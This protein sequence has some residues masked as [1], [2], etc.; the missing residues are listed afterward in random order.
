MQWAHE[1]K[2]D[3]F[4]DVIYT[5]ECT[6]Q[7]ESYR[8]FC[9]QKKGE[10]PCPK[11][12]PKHP[13]K[14]HVWA[15][16]SLQGSTGICIFDGIM[17]RTLYISILQQTLLPFIQSVYPDGHRFMANNDPKHTSRDAQQVLENNDINWWRTP[18]VT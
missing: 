18:A 6:V 8:R 5:D 11:P 2:D 3:G 4:A 17:D 10:A 7:I 14:V 9:C 16:I 15:G 1:Y 13:L 12:R